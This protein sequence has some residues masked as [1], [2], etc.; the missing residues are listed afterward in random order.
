MNKMHSPCAPV[1]QV[2]NLLIKERLQT[3]NY[4]NPISNKEKMKENST[5]IF[6]L[7]DG[8]AKE[9]Q[10][11]LELRNETLYTLVA[12]RDTTDALCG[13][14]FHLLARHHKIFAKL[15]RTVLRNSG[16]PLL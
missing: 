4:T 11:P 3:I 8:L 2:I 16:T 10:D 9:T 6:V 7:L 15:R 14:T 1:H 5:R 13:W 12:G